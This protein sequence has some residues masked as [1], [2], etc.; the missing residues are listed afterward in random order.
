MTVCPIPYMT[1]LGGRSENHSPCCATCYYRPSARRP[2]ERPFE[3]AWERA[4]A[5][6]ERG[7]VTIEKVAWAV[8]VIAFVALAAAAIRAYVTAQAGRLG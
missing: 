2:V 3:E 6:P 8:A 1:R 4:K 5:E 7:S